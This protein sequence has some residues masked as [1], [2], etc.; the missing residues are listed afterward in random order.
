LHAFGGHTNHALGAAAT[1]WRGL[2][3]P[4]LEQ[5]FGFEAIDGGIQRADGALASD[6]RL[7]LLANGRTVSFVAES[8]SRSDQQVFEFAK[9]D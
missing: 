9:H 4:R 8:G 5:P 7:D 3:H 1:L 6:R 2:A